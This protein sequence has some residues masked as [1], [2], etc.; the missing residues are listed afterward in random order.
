MEQLIRS[1]CF[2][3]GI[4]GDVVFELRQSKSAK[5]EGRSHQASAKLVA[6]I[7]QHQEEEGG[8]TTVVAEPRK[9]YRQIEQFRNQAGTSGNFCCCR[10]DFAAAVETRVGVRRSL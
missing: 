1:Y 9:K 2:R 4:R 10:S 5:A 7:Q 8:R 3:A 6:A